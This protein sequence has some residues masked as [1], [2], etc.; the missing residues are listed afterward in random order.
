MLLVAGMFLE[1]LCA[2]TICGPLLL[3]LVKAYGISPLHFG[4][5]MCVNLAIGLTTPPVGA[6]LYV[7]AGVAKIPLERTFRPL[8]IMLVANMA[9]L[10]LITYVEPLVMFL[11][12]VLGR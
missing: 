6:S 2:I 7:A 9:A 3:A 10:T 1:T 8:G 11:P 5:I 4:V 12:R